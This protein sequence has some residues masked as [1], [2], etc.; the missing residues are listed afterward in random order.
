MTLHFW[1]DLWASFWQATWPVCLE[2]RPL[3]HQGEWREHWSFW[4]ETHLKFTKE[5]ISSLTGSYYPGQNMFKWFSFN[6]WLL[7]N[8]PSSLHRTWNASLIVKSKMNSSYSNFDC[9]CIVYSFQVMGV[10]KYVTIE[11]TSVTGSVLSSWKRAALMAFRGR[12]HRCTGQHLKMKETVVDPCE[13]MT[14]FLQSHK[15]VRIGDWQS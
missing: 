6:I 9:L 4:N 15:L 8:A 3:E 1:I 14:T 12:G 11:Y 10:Y 5:R 13:N 2:R 7:L